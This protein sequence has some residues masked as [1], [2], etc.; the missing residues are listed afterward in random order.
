MLAY[1]YLRR[2][3][4]KRIFR[5]LSIRRS[6][7]HGIINWLQHQLPG[8]TCFYNNAFP[9]QNVYKSSN[10][11]E[12]KIR[13]LENEFNI[14]FNIENVDLENINVSG[15]GKSTAFHDLLI[16]RDPFNC[17][18][19]YLN[20]N[21]PW[22]TF[23]KDQ[24]EYRTYIKNRW[25]EHAKEALSETNY[26][27]NKIAI[28]FNSWALDTGYR[29][30]ISKRLGFK[31]TDN[32]F[33][34]KPHYGLGSS[35]GNNPNDYFNRWKSSMNDK[36]FLEIFKGEKELQMLSDALFGEIE[37]TNKLFS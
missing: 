20:A 37:G 13:P 18:A 12:S 27:E 19:S 8:S 2:K 34:H 30:G 16:I 5:V 4:D 9:N 6:G 11:K 17:F 25:K 14:I 24:S 1:K 10:N 15:I 33:D 28:N 22:D 31:F 7:Q 32:G 23:F 26:L 21:W 35:F 3:K 29:K 36:R